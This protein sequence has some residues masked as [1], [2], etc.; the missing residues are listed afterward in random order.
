MPPTSAD[1]CRD[2]RAP[3]LC[4]GAALLRGHPRCG[5]RHPLA[6]QRQGVLAVD[7]RLLGAGG[8]FQ[9]E[10]FLSNE[11]AFQTVI[12][13]L[14]A[15][16]PAG[17]VYL[18][19]GPEQNF[20]YIVALRPRL[21]FIIDIR[22]G[23]LIEH[24]LY[25]AFVE[26]SVDSRGIPVSPVREETAGRSGRQRHGRRVVRGVRE[27]A[28]ER[29]SVQG[30]PPG[31]ERPAGQG[32]QV[33]AVGRRF[34][35]PRVR[36]LGLLRGG[37]A[38]N[39]SFSP[40]GGGGLRRRVSEL[41]RPDERDRR[42]GRATQLSGHG[43]ELS[44]PPRISEEQCDRAGGRRLRRRQGA[45]R[46]GRLRASARCH[47]DRVLHLER[48]AVS[49]SRRRTPGGSS[50]RTS[51]RFHS[52]RRA[53]SSD[54]SRTAGSRLPSSA[55][56][57]RLRGRRPRSRPL[58]SSSRRSTPDRSTDTM[59]WSRCRNDG[60]AGA[61]SGDRRPPAALARGWP[62]SADPQG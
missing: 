38:L 44:R 37:P 41:S 56:S 55:G 47:G 30:E 20:T 31:G 9:S 12:P 52:I 46:R 10:N 26:M 5:R 33:R 4:L 23:N 53:H 28:A 17:G 6:A 50:S 22:R 19:V 18:G 61:T 40:A 21:A 51:R 1:C 11:N 54:R 36:L 15:T 39:Y 62:A 27:R 25:K 16:L 8:S 60:R 3:H 48:R 2:R 35:G 42:P 13:E 49:V 45:S 24:L 7:Q 34:Q 59:T 29:G 58:P 57:R 43:R 32:S 14:K